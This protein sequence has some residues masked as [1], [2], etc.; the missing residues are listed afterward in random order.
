MAVEFYHLKKK[1][2]A[3]KNAGKHLNLE[4]GGALGWTGSGQ[5][6]AGVLATPPREQAPGRLCLEPCAG[7]G[8][9]RGE[10]RSRVFF[11]FFFLI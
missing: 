1:M 11:F 6:G 5:G 7:L 2:D 3:R 10:Q 4:W 8:C 9:P